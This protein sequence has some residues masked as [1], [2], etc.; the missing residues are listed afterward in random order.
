[1]YLGVY[2]G[3]LLIVPSSDKLWTWIVAQLKAKF[4]MHV[5]GDV[6]VILGTEVE[7]ADD[8][9]ICLHQG[10]AVDKLLACCGQDNAHPVTVPM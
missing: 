10:Q 8:G 2:V 6:R 1:M 9:S 7:Y 3:D 5:L 4:K